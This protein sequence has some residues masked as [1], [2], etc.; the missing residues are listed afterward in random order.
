MKGAGKGG[1]DLSI[2][3]PVEA[4]IK[5]HDNRDGTCD[6]QYIPAKAGVHDI[7]VNFADHAIPGQLLCH[8]TGTLRFIG[9]ASPQCLVKLNSYP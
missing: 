5:C 8:V 4:E 6:V 7:F 3:G 2:Q 9:D 1:L